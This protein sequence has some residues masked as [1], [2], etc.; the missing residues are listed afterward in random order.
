MKITAYMSV[1]SF[2]IFRK[3]EKVEL[4]VVAELVPAKHIHSYKLPQH[5]NKNNKTFLE[6]LRVAWSGRYIS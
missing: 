6:N 1:S 5:E 2:R 3:V 4:G